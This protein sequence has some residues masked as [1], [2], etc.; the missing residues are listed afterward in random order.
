MHTEQRAILHTYVPHFQTKFQHIPVD[1]TA[2]DV[3]QQAIHL[4]STHD[5]GHLEQ[6]I[7]EEEI[8]TAPR[9]GTKHKAPGVDG[10]C[11]EFYPANWE[12]LHTDLGIS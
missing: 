6:P 2:I 9:A 8:H 12:T 10:F 1:T 7:T 5:A 11:L 4:S 3:I